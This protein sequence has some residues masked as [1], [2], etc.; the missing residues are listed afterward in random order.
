MRAGLRG[1]L[2]DSPVYV[3]ELF[4]SLPFGCRVTVADQ[5]GALINLEPPRLE[6]GATDDQL[7]AA[8]EQVEQATLPLGPSNSY[9]FS[10]AIHGIRRR[11]AASASRERGEGLLHDE[12]LL[13]RS[14][15]LLLRHD[16]RC[17]YREMPARLAGRDRQRSRE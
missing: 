1:P 16:R 6:E 9:F 10:I 4:H 3:Q 8:F 14:L 15:P 17:L 7:P 11:S 13:A 2:Y 5:V 12:E